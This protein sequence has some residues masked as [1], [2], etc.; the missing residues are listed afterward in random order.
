MFIERIKSFR[1]AGT[2]GWRISPFK[3]PG[4]EK[5]G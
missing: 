2:A 3:R 5:P 4:L 1:M